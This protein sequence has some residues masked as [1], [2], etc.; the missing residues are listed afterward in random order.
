MIAFVLAGLVLLMG[1]SVFFGAPYLPTRR[2]WAKAALDLAKISK[3]DLVVDLGSGDGA[4]LRLVAGCGARS[5]GYEINP[6]LWLIA[7]IRLCRDR[8]KPEVYLA[9][10]WLVDLPAETTIVYAFCVQ[11]DAAKLEKYLSKQK[12]KK[13]KVI[14]FGFKLPNRKPV[15]HNNGACLYIF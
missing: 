7:K 4:I 12:P 15:K 6:I 14:T 11:R 13:L 8:P 3:K 5:I 2:R 1:F 10:Y 9:N